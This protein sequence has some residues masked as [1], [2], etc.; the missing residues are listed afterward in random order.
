[1]RKI[2]LSIGIAFIF[3]GCA[4]VIDAL[5]TAV[6]IGIKVGT[7]AHEIRETSKEHNASERID[8]LI[9]LEP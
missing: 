7:V 3:T 4:D 8:R 2:I 5:G 6:D 9:G 1:M